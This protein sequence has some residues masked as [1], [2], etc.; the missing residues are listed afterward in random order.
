MTRP[1]VLPQTTTAL[2][3]AAEVGKKTLVLV[4]KSFLKDQWAERVAQYL[5]AARVTAIQGDE[6]DTSGDVVVAMIQ[7]LV[8]RRY[9]PST[10]EPFGLVV[11][12]EVHHLGAEAFSQS[13]WGLCAPRVLGLSATPDR[14]DGLTRVVTWFVGP[15]AY[16]ARR[17]NQVATVVRTVGYWCPE[18]DGPPPVNRRGDVC[19]TT[20]ITRLAENRERTAAVAA[21]TKRLADDGRDVLVLTHRRQHATDLADE[22]RRLGVDAATY[23]GGDKRAPDSRV[24]V[25]TYALTSEGFDMPRLD[26]LVLATGRPSRR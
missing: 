18:F 6:C 2:Y 15:V 3:L 25:A 21:E 10:F 16:R 4:H 7:T 26:A 12:D 23:L 1:R 11:V 8:S 20:T 19:F 5:P 17:E 24:V 22:L 14:K 9:P 13:M